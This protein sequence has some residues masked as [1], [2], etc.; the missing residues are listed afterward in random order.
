[1]R[2]QLEFSLYKWKD[3]SLTF[4]P[5]EWAMEVYEQERKPYITVGIN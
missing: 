3:S 2:E 5:R 4:Y 1:M